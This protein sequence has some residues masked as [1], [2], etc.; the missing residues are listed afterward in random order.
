MEG[1]NYLK[2]VLLITPECSVVDL[3]PTLSI[4]NIE[5][6]PD[7]DWRKNILPCFYLCKDPRKS[8]NVATALGIK[9]YF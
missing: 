6:D 2:G 5:A 9:H 3:L 8:R 7:P 1:S 4:S